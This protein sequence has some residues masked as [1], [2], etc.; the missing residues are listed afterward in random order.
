M[1]ITQDIILITMFF[2][3]MHKRQNTQVYNDLINGGFTASLSG[4]KFSG[5]HGDYI[6]ETQNGETKRAGGPFKSGLISNICTFN[7]WMRT[8]HIGAERQNDLRKI[9]HIKTSST[10]RESTPYGL[11]RH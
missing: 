8:R 11:C 9:L 2:F 3:L 7:T 6:C 4:S 5:V 10:H 1:F